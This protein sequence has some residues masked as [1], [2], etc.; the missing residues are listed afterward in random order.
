[1]TNYFNIYFSD[2]S[3]EKQEEVRSFVKQDLEED[4][5]IMERIEEVAEEEIEEHGNRVSLKDRIELLLD[6][7]TDDEARKRFTAKGEV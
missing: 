2:L 1:M 3:F 7:E 5:N 4:D 6:E